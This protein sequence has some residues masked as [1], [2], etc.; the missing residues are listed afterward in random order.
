MNEDING[1]MMKSNKIVTI[2]RLISVI[3]TEYLCVIISPLSFYSLLYLEASDNQIKSSWLKA[4][5]HLPVV[6]SAYKL[7]KDELTQCLFGKKVL[8]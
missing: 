8:W 6:G 5:I 1:K 3:T 7:E 2:H 4:I